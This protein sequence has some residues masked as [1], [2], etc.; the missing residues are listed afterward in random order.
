MAL[1]TLGEQA[2]KTLIKFAGQMDVR[3]DAYWEEELGHQF[4]FNSTQGELVRK[5]LLHAKE[6]NLRSAKRL[7]ASFVYYGFALGKEIPGENVWK[8]AEA[9]E[10]V[11]TALLMHDDFMDRDKV[12]RGLPTTQEFFNDGDIHYGESMAVNTGDAVLCLGFERL[13]D[14]G[15]E[16]EKVKKATGQLL[17]G[18]TN[19]AYGQ[20]YDVSLPRLG[21]M[22]EEKVMNLHRAKT[23]IYTYEN[24]LFIGAMLAGLPEESLEILH[25]YS[26]AGGVA[27]QLQDDILGIF[28]DEEKTGKSADSDLLQGK[29]TLLIVK[30]LEM[31]TEG[32]KQI[33]GKVWG[34]LS[35]REEDIL[36]AKKAIKESG[37]YEYS[38]NI[39]KEMAAE[40]ADVAAQ[41]RKMDLSSEAID[42]LEGVARYMAERE[43]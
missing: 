21:E 41:L 5:I 31:G 39:S 6:H 16:P 40:A 1:N 15:F 36:L 23:A 4:G 37:A 30:V 38:L 26:V 25:K 17:R 28:G 7:R 22:T 43:V 33:L 2:K 24:P 34:K 13:L 27:F 10:L 11:H 12:R 9:I 29:V 42:Y 35:A 3:L 18:I 20:A 14:C 19:T 8:A 32:Q